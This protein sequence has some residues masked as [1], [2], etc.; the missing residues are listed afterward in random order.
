MSIRASAAVTVAT[1]VPMVAAATADATVVF[2]TIPDG[3]TGPSGA[4]QLYQFGG[5]PLGQKLGYRFVPDM[6]GGVIQI[7]A[8]AYNSSGTVGPNARFEIYSESLGVPGPLL[9][10]ALV[11]LPP[12]VGQLP[13]GLTPTYVLDGSIQL[14]AGQPYYVVIAPSS[15]SALV[16]V[17]WWWTTSLPPGMQVTNCFRF[18]SSA[19]WEVFSGLSVA[20]GITVSIPAPLSGLAVLSGCCM[21]LC[22]RRR[23]SL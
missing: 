10:S 1:I 13:S 18:G 21:A 3:V 8:W 4:N 6:S 7:G 14:V 19:P 17:D 22:R 16:R 12:R 11:E 23:H 9:G 2:S 20:A 15:P 5:N